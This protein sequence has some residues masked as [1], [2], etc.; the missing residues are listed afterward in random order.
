MNVYGRRASWGGE[1]GLSGIIEIKNYVFSIAVFCCNVVQPWYRNH[2]RSINFVRLAECFGGLDPMN[3][4]ALWYL[5]IAGINEHLDILIPG[6]NLKPSVV[7]HGQAL[8]PE[9][10]RRVDRLPVRKEN[11]NTP[12]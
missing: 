11:T 6:A 10:Q 4:K 3:L 12:G 5:I 9:V 8:I 1:I 2:H 7:S